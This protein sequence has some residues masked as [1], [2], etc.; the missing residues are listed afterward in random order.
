MEI[1]DL[2][3]EIKINTDNYN[4]YRRRQDNGGLKG[5]APQDQNQQFISSQGAVCLESP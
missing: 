3:K 4:N 2:M 5:A 1:R